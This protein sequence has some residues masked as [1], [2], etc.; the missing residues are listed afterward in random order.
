MGLCCCPMGTIMRGPL[1]IS[2]A[3]ADRLAAVRRYD[4]LDTLRVA[5]RHHQPA[6]PEPRAI[7]AQVPALVL[8]PTLREGFRCLPL[9]HLRGSVLRRVDHVGRAAD[10][11]CLGPSSNRSAPAFHEVTRRSRSV[12]KIA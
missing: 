10:D 8:G 11:R 5:Q 2:D 3:E 12:V 1:G 6:C 9:R 4:I 7:L